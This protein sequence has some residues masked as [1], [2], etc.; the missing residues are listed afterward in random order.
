M[1]QAKEQDQV[2]SLP[3]LSS[4]Y[5]CIA[6]TIH[7]G[8]TV[9]FVFFDIKQFRVLVKQ[10]GNEKACSIMVACWCGVR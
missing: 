5:D 6:K 3:F 9:G 8:Q 7:K 1:A 2:T 10:Q 4:L